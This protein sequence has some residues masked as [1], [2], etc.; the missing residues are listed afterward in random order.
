VAIDGLAL[1]RT[2]RPEYD[3]SRQVAGRLADA[4]DP[5]EAKS[6][7]LPLVGTNAEPVQDLAQ[8]S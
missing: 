5:C 2:E 7:G 8:G 6:Q 1:A 3:E 4:V